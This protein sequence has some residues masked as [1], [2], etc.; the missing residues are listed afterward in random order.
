MK[1]ALPVSI[2]RRPGEPRPT[3]HQRAGFTLLELMIVVAIVATLLTIAVPGYRHAV[4]T[5]LETAAI[6]E[7][8]QLETKIDLFEMGTG[9]LPLDLSDLGEG[10]ILDPWGNAYQYL[11]FE[12]TKGKGKGEQRKDKFLVPLNTKYDLYSM[13]PDGQSKAPLT[14]KVSRD[15]ILR[16]NDGDYVGVASG[17]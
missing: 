13:G 2:S 9:S 5:T 3:R 17:Y 16:A 14:A 7:I 11:N 15:D 8:K 4:E 6:Q 12:T 1:R 10:M